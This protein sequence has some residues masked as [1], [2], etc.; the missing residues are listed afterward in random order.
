MKAKLFGRQL[1]QMRLNGGSAPKKKN[2]FIVTYGRLFT[3]GKRELL[4]KGMSF[5]QGVTSIA[6]MC[7]KLCLPA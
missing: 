7:D 1:S 5:W 6:P 4:P 2:G 3:I